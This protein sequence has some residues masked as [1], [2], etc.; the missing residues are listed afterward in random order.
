ME[1]GWTRGLA[2]IVAE[3]QRFYRELGTWEKVEQETGLT[4]RRART[5]INIPGKGATASPRTFQA[6]PLFLRLSAPAVGEV[7]DSVHRWVEAG[8]SFATDHLRLLWD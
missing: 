5:F 4:A 3:L 7:H 2:M 6:A 8:V 1:A